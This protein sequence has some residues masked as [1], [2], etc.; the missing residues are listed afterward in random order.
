ME[1]NKQP[2]RD[3]CSK[4]ASTTMNHKNMAALVGMEWLEPGLGP[5]GFGWLD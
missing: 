4:E 3:M 2:D 1:I 5:C